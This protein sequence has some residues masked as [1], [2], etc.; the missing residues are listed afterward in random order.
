MV[1]HLRFWYNAPF[2]LFLSPFTY[3]AVLATCKIATLQGPL[4]SCD[5]ILICCLVF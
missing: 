4:T 5:K 1:I 2:Y 3:I